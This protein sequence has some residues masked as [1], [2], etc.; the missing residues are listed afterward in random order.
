MK[1]MSHK[2]L[3]RFG[4]VVGVMLLLGGG[5]HA[6]QGGSALPAL[7]NGQAMPSLADVIE[8][9]I[10]A[11]V[12]IATSTRIQVPEHPLLSDPFFRQ[13]FNLPQ[14]RGRREREQKSL[15]SGV[16][17]DAQKGIVLTNQ[18]VIDKADQITVTL[19]N[20]R[21]VRAKLLGVD[22]ATDIAVIQ[23]PTKHLQDLPLGN[24]DQL[25][26]GDFVVA[27]GNPFGL[28][29]TVT[30][31][32]VS[33]LG[34]KGLGIKGYED[35]IQTDA[36]IN[37]GNSGGALVNLRGELIGINTAILARGGGNVGI[38]FAIPVNMARRIMEQLLRYGKVKRGVLGIQSQ[39]LTVEL[40]EAFAIGSQEGAVVVQV[41]PGSSADKA[42]LQRGDVVIKANGR[43]IHSTADLHNM[44]GLSRTGERIELEVI[45]DGNVKG[46]SVLIAEP[47]RMRVLGEKLDK[48]LRGS[49][50]EVA[51]MATGVDT[52]TAGIYVIAVAVNSMAW[53]IGLRAGDWILAVN[54]REANSF[55]GLKAALK[56]A[57]RKLLLTIR[58]GNEDLFILVR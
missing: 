43:P 36:S 9:V 55:P 6:S 34:R 19:R 49:Q 50:L 53:R 30:S 28:G 32:I 16:V 20:G 38:G 7:I 21:S 18:H 47:K 14:Q 37:P 22:A 1:T 8:P 29:Q 27:I 31:G 58:R 17:V 25:R 51:D 3:S 23:V 24:S 52:E 5:L 54:R 46:V 35:F 48:R 44:V 26:V 13:F 39:D 2:G 15:G 40:A 4:A 56:K 45:Q 11:V 12:N 41:I 10:A 57:K 33:A 42:G